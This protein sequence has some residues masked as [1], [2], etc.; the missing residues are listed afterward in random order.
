[1]AEDLEE[2]YDFDDDDEEEELGW[3][4][5]YLAICVFMPMLN[6]FINGYSWGGYALYYTSMGWPLSR[7]G[8]S[9]LI[10][11]GIR[12]L[13]QQIQIRC[14][15]W[16]II[17]LSVVHLAGA[18]LGLIYTTEEWAVSL[19]M[20]S[21]IAFEPAITWEGLA[22]DVFGKSELMARQ[23]SSTQLA[24]YTFSCAFGVTIGGII[25]DFAGW[26]GMS[27]FHVVCQ[28]L[29]LALF[30]AQPS[31]QNSFREFFT[32]TSTSEIEDTSLHHSP[33]PTSV[34]PTEPAHKAPA[35]DLPMVLE[36]IEEL[37]GEVP[38]EKTL[39]NRSEAPRV[40]ECQ[41][42]PPARPSAGQRRSARQSCK[43]NQSGPMRHSLVSQGSRQTHQTR[44]TLRTT[45]SSKT[46][47]SKGTKGTMLSRVT[48]LTNLK[49]SENFQ[50]SFMANNA[51]RPTLA[52]RAGERNGPDTGHEEV[53]V[54]NVKSTSKAVPRDLRLPALMVMLCCF[55][56]NLS[57][58]FE[59][60]TFA[61]FFKE[62]HGWNDAMLAS[63]AQTAG[64]LTAGVM[65]KVFGAQTDDDEDAGVLRRLI[66]Q[67]YSL[68]CLLVGWSL[69]NLG[70][71]SPW[72][73]LAVTAQVLMG[74]VYVYTCKLTSDL[75]LFYS[76]GDQSVF[77]SLQVYCKNMEA[78]GGC[79]ASFLGP[80][81]VETVSP[82]APF[83]VSTALATV[84]FI[85]FTLGFCHRLG[86]PPD[87]EVAEARRA[88][89]LGLRRVSAWSVMSRKS[90]VMMEQEP[91]AACT[92][93]EKVTSV[94]EVPSSI[95][96]P[97]G[98]WGQAT[99]TAEV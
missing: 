46:K 37:P 47:T 16:A 86:F 6:G 88:R 34:V 26:Q 69:C 10:G 27:V 48:A 43:S 9:C 36:D 19:E 57:Y 62:Y 83:F 5:S 32:K 97:A 90:T 67:P 52:Q 59:F 4:W 64:D 92:E 23:A 81:L 54:T 94:A 73:P 24:V 93:S 55:N 71:T 38:E 17:P 30:I 85:L 63:F 99:K 28:A 49:D 65:M 42:S 79:L 51:L 72:L 95:S 7:S 29:M 96:A 11:F 35:S 98:A 13:F 74:T 80:L 1:M 33:E 12:P 76:L 56:N 91:S 50:H 20:G 44:V 77:L 82:F 31:C 61:V 89:R 68:A 3:S 84:T 75:N 8:A 25:Y 58:M 41:T 53:K 78:L 14:G 45:K 39:A 21:W 70:M 22:F 18:I 40:S 87:I 15:F 66:K 60:S 2:W